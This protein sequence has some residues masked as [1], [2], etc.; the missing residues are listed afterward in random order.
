MRPSSDVVRWHQVE[1]RSLRSYLFQNLVAVIAVRAA[2]TLAAAVASV[3]AVS[4]LALQSVVLCP[5]EIV[6]GLL[7]LYTAASS[8]MVVLHP[9]SLHLLAHRH[10]QHR[11][12]VN[13]LVASVVVMQ[14]SG[15]RQTRRSPVEHRH[16]ARQMVP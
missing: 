8:V 13:L 7:V 2:Q 11:H 16:L 1:G 5:Y 12:L 9:N 3:S 10:L 4:V 6:L 15:C 14:P